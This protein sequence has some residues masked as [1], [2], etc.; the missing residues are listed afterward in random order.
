M[1][2]SYTSNKKIGQLDTA[3]T[4][5]GLND[6]FVVNQAGD[7]LKTPLSAVEAKVFS[8]DQKSTQTTPSGTEMVVVR[9]TDN[10]LRQVAL[11]NIVPAA[12]ITND[13]VA[14]INSPSYLGITDD[15]LAT[16]NTAGKVTNTAVQASTGFT[17]GN[18][19]NA[20]G[21]NRI[22]TR[23][24][25]GNFAAGT[26]TATLSGNASTASIAS[27]VADGSV[28]T[29][30]IA[31]SA[32]TSAKIADGTIVNGDISGTAG[33]V[34]TKLATIGTA[35]KVSN[36]ATTATS[37]NTA[38]AIVARDA[39]GNFL[40]GTITANITG[41]VSGNA[42]T[43][44]NGLYT[45]AVQ[46]N[47]AQK[48]FQSGSG[49]G[50]ATNTG[51]LNTL[52]VIGVV[53][54]A[55][56][57]TFHRPGSFATYLGVDTDNQLKVGGWS[58]GANAYP[59][60]TSGNYNSYA[61]TLTGTGAS[62]TWGINITGNAATAGYA[63]SAGTAAAVSSGYVARAMATINSNGTIAA[64]QSV[65]G[66]VESHRSAVGRYYLR[67]NGIGTPQYVVATPNTINRF[68]SLTTNPLGMASINGF[69]FNV[70]VEINNSGGSG[71]PAATDTS[72]IIVVF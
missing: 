30:K 48:S 29:A 34:D 64:S 32:V 13:K 71:N 2:T 39:S 35:G 42:G 3:S 4:P 59:I 1:A 69:V 27:S 33:I 25:S 50:M 7:T 45:N 44:T 52:E 11:S 38:S 68:V 8:S 43:V 62:G 10:V 47:T 46:T 70:A 54:G 5:L 26:I 24:S 16:I 17:G 37:A 19:D 36:S 20:V 21:A 15:K 53:N 40:A 57:M 61:P 63:N 66:S 12:N 58:L 72:F 56:M 49:S 28:T 23:D 67:F 9:Q 51:G 65:A 31:D 22:V 41:N 18:Y 55:A 6:E 14:P 60:L